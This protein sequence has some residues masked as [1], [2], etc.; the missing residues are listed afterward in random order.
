MDTYYDEYATPLKFHKFSKWVRLPLGLIITF[1]Q[2][3]QIMGYE[4][5]VRDYYTVDLIYG[6]IML[7][8]GCVAFYGLCTWK[9]CG[10]I[11][12][13]A[14][15][16]VSVVY[17]LFAV[18]VVAAYNPDALG[19]SIGSLL[20]S[21]I[22]SALV[23][24]YYLKRR[25]LFF[26]HI[27]NAYIYERIRQAQPEGFEGV[28]H[29]D[30]RSGGDPTVCRSCGSKLNLSRDTCMRCGTAIPKEVV[31][32]AQQETPAAPVPQAQTAVAEPAPVSAARFCH[33]CGNQLAEGSRFCSKCGTQIVS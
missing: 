26:E 24:I 14:Y 27:R 23:I 32:A 16:V 31:A 3:F 1:V 33:K 2:V 17:R 29:L 19:S 25:P 13:I 30:D 11:G 4:P 6:V 21:G 18:F 9:P 20:G 12:M 7:A 10:F 28:V 5:Y 15:E 22:V 8:I